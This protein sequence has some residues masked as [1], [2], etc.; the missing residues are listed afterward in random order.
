LKLVW[1]EYKSDRVE[2][3]IGHAVSMQGL[4][5]SHKQMQMK[6]WRIQNEDGMEEGKNKESEMRKETRK[7]REVMYSSWR[8]DTFLECERSKSSICPCV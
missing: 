7:E 4:T 1:N 8:A 2:D 6:K 3:G 5:T